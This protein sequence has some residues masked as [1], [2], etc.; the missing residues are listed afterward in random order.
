VSTLITRCPL[1][2]TAFRVTAAQLGAAAGLVRCGAC[3][4]VF[5][6]Q[7]QLVAAEPAL[8][9]PPGLVT[10]SPTAFGLDESYIRDLLREGPDTDAH[11]QPS[12]A[13]VHA[14]ALATGPEEADAAPASAAGG[15]DADA[16]ADAGEEAAALVDAQA[17][18][19]PPAFAPPPIEIGTPAQAAP[20][21]RRT[22]WIL[23]CIAAALALLAQLAWHERDRLVRD[24]DWRPRLDTA[25]AL[26]GCTP[27]RPRDTALIRSDGL[28][29]RPA[30]GREGVLLVDALLS[31]LAAYPQAWPQLEI[32]FSDMQ[33]RA[34]AGRVFTPAEYLP[35]KPR[36]DMPVRQAV[37]VHLEI[38]DP[39][40]N[41]TNY[42][43][44][45]RP[46]A[47]AG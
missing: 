26:L 32:V 25:C 27:A 33:G 7:R 39:G 45:V 24:P 1:C 34:L 9:L 11:T 47:G 40:A 18:A 31:N 8:N 46:A 37:A 38:S 12:C 21:P 15:A 3:S 30:P 43:L 22:G 17:P 13:P 29:I 4:H 2:Q 28:V 23:G 20:A 14:G 41:A 44:F 35:A 19:S 5:E 42:R 10:P 16:D 36:G 6:A